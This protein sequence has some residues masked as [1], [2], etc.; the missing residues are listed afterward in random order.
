MVASMSSNSDYIKQWL[1]EAVEKKEAA[2]ANGDD[3]SFVAATLDEKNY[4]DML[5][6][7]GDDDS[8]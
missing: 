4:R 1:A 2:R 3:E 7:W 6:R 5:G 8:V